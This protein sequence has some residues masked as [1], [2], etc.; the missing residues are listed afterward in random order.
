[1]KNHMNRALALLVAL[2]VLCAPVGAM[3]EELNATL[4][5][6]NFA[7][8]VGEDINVNLDVTAQLD[9]TA[10]MENGSIAGT[11]TALAA[12]DKALKAG[13]NFDLATMN[14]TAGLEGMTDGVLVPMTDMITQLQEQMNGMFSEEDMAKVMNLINAYMNLTTVASEK[15]EALAAALQDTVAA[16]AAKALT[17][18]GDTTITIED[19]ELAAHQYDVLLTAKDFAEVGAVAA[20]VFMD[21]PE[22]AAALQAY[23]DAIVDLSGEESIDLSAMD[24]DALMAQ[25]AELDMNVAASLY[26]ID[27]ANLVLDITVNVAENGE[28]VSIPMEF[29]VLTDEESTYVSYTIDASMEDGETAII[30]IEADIP[31]GETPKFSFIV[32]ATQGDDSMG[33][34]ITISLEGDFSEGANVTFY[35]QVESSYTYGENTYTSLQAFGLNYVGT[36]SYDETGISC[37]GKLTLYV[38]SDGQEITFG[39]DTLVR[40][41]AASTVDF[42][43]PHNLIDITKA[44][45][46]TMNAL[47]E[48]AMTVLQ[49]GVMVLMGAPGMENLLPLIQG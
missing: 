33:Q 46:D 25:L 39:A 29:I 24:I 12:K 26:L 44:D 45:E 21:D 41:N 7:L 49:Q 15:G 18:V 40:L 6:S 19:V 16:I 9:L 22:L 10:D 23:V 17:D 8:I 27:D 34:D 35:G 2:L 5:L 42:E 32:S 3:A 38:N 31:T 48:E 47:A 28:A 20:H 13:F 11:L 43:M 37:P 1:M 14:L 36:M 30:T 4:A